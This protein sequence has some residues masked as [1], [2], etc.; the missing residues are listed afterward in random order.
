MKE[1]ENENNLEA[2]MYVNR[3]IGLWNVRKLGREES[4]KVED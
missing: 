4:R 2:D 3:K 1:K